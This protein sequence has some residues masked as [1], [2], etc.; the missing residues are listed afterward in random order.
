LHHYA[1]REPILLLAGLLDTRHLNDLV[2]RLLRR[3]SPYERYLH[4]DLRLAAALLGEHIEL[5]D[6]LATR[7]IDHLGWLIRNHR[8]AWK[9]RLTWCATYL[10]GGVAIWSPLLLGDIRPLGALSSWWLYGGTLFWTLAW[11]CAFMK[12]T[13]PKIQTYLALP[14]RLWWAAPRPEPFIQALS[15]IGAPAL[16]ALL[17]ALSAS[18]WWVRQAAAQALARIGTPQAIPV[19]LQALGDSEERVRRAAAEALGELGAPQA[20]PVL[21]QALGDCDERVRRA[22][23]RALGQLGTPQAIPPLLQALGASDEA[24][25]WTAAEALGKLTDIVSDAQVTRRVAG[26]LWER[27]TDWELVREAAC[28]ALEQVANR[29]TI[30]D[31]ASHSLQDPLMAARPTPPP[32]WKQFTWVLILL[33][34]LGFLDLLKGVLTNLLS[35]YLGVEWLPKGSAGLILLILGPVGFYILYLLLQNREASLDTQKGQTTR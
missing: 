6:K 30:L 25:R 14:S 29:L 21:L 3:P 15:D 13:F 12:S 27:L 20:I 5:D 9:M 32:A 1:W 19:L 35:D 22:A 4:R 8:A 17:Q 7:I 31:V 10:V 2:R 33:V 11:V 18:Q 24:M 34:G 16:S 26:A 23:A 28:Q